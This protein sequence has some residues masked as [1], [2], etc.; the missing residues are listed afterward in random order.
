MRDEDETPPRFPLPPVLQDAPPA[1]AAGIARLTE[2]LL[3]DLP[4]ALK[5][6]AAGFLSRLLTMPAEELYALL[7][8]LGA[9]RTVDGKPVSLAELAAR[10]GLSGK[11]AFRFV[12]CRAVSRVPEMVVFFPKTDFRFLRSDEARLRAALAAGATF[13]RNLR[14]NKRGFLVS[15]RGPWRGGETIPAALTSCGERRFRPRRGP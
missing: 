5:T 10:C 11:Q 6:K 4:P 2:R 8:M 14:R 12:L 13:P 7:Q 9:Q 15:A 3:P 1:W